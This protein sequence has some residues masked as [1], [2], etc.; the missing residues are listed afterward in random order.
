MRRKRLFTSKLWLPA[1]ASLLL[2]TGRGALAQMTTAAIHG[3]VTDPSGAVVP[4]AKVIALNTA[5]GISTSTTS[6]KSG[7]YIFT[8]LQ[9]GDYAI[10]VDAFGF[11]NFSATSV[12][13][14]ANANREVN[15]VLKIGGGAQTVQ[16]TATA[17]QVETSNTQLE[18]VATSDELESLPLEGRDPAGLAKLEPGIMESSDR[19]GSF[20]SNGNQTAQNSYMIDGAD[21]NDGPLQNE[22]IQVNPDALSGE[23]IVTSTMNPEFARNSGQVVNEVIKSGTN[24]IHG[25]GFEFYRD[26]FLNNGN[27]FATTRPVFHQNLYGGTV[28]GPMI[29]NKLFAFLAYQGYR[30]RTATTTLQ[31]T[32]SGTKSTTSP[33]GQFAGAFSSDT[34]WGM[35]FVAD[36]ATFSNASTN[37][38]NNLPYCANIP[39]GTYS[40]SLSC[41]PTPFSVNGMPAGTPWIEAFNNGGAGSATINIAPSAWN[42]IATSLIQNY[43]PAANY[44]VSAPTEYNFNALNTGAE[45]QGIVRLDYTLSSRDS[46]W[47]SSVFQ[48]SP[49]FNTLPFGGS[50]F[51]GS[52]QV[53]AEHF[54]IFSGDWTHTFSSNKLNDLHGGYYRFNFAAVIPAQPVQP[55]TA[56]FDITPQLAA[57]A[58]I[59]YIGV[60]GLFNL[61]FS[62]EGP[63]PRLDTNLTYLDSFTWVRGN[64][65][66]KFGASFEQF[67]VH[68]PFGYYNNG[69]YSFDGGVAGGG[70]YSSGD[71][72]IDFV[73]GIPDTYSQTNDGFIDAVANETYFYVQ[74]NWRATPD[75]TLNFGSGWD[76]EQP[77]QNR[78]YNGL[79]IIC[80]ANNSTTSK[81][82]PGG[83]PGLTYS[84]DPGC[85]AAGSPTTKYNHF[86]PRVGFAW[87]PSS[88]P[89]A[90]NGHPGEHDFSIRAG[91]GIYFNRDQ[92]E[93]SLQNLGDPP[94]LYESHGASDFGGSPGFANPYA[95]VAGNGSEPNPY[96]YTPPSA[97]GAVNWGVY[98]Q[99]DV[100]AFAPT[101]SVPYAYNFNL[102]IQRSLPGAMLLQV[103][104]V[105]SMGHHTTTWFEGDNITQSGHDACLANP[106]CNPA[107]IHLFFPQYTAQPAIVPGTGNG[108]IS[109]L[110]NG[111]PWYLS[112][113]N[114]NTEG[115][116]NYNAFQMSLIKSPT[117]GLQFTLGYTYSHA[118]DDSSGY[119]SG[120]GGDGG[121][122]NG[123]R[124][125]NYV[126]GF[127]YLNYGDSDY[128]ARQRLVASYVY[129]IPATGF[130]RSNAILREGLSGWGIGGLTAVQDGFPISVTMGAQRSYWCDGYSYFGCPDVPE[131]SSF[132]IKRFNPR[133]SANN[134]YFDT[135]PFSPEPLGTFGNTRRNFF[136][137]PG[138]NYTNLEIS[139]NFPFSAEGSRYLQMR[140]EAF[141]AFNH[142]NFAP[143]GGSYA[144]SAAYGQVFGAVNSVIV[145]QDPNADPQPGRAVQL[146][147]K[148]YF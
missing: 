79:G 72:L 107:S 8:Q 103:G 143:P 9:V 44:P 48:S 145:S 6:D 20:S 117:H 136:H 62:F 42:S 119:E 137:G 80:W 120:T 2:F 55:S 82:Y 43:V 11:Q 17:V 45:D 32:L 132:S 29:K 104:Y 98:S 90:L 112:V 67:R 18:Q 19:F 118:L 31:P 87:S 100:N 66:L 47:G 74:D 61:G 33:P 15:A 4:G 147:G 128:D 36:N 50:S 93:Q 71:P 92:E 113:A 3:T 140:L 123:G 126:P 52:P 38:A 75:L 88:G 49:S 138:F 1:I 34:N 101:Y 91:F 95:D 114:Q 23:T 37:P 105:G 7:Y 58:G 53:G 76:A 110:P 127:Q 40:D 111:V 129:T 70:D 131:T 144:N 54:K 14:N 16:V 21:I 115:S 30:N 99:L 26:T 64:H 65:T 139:K 81:I 77:N 109:G 57:G 86:A 22:G 148:V 94:A 133:S 85:N 73:L 106:S 146:V 41:N 130:L 124:V 63:Q 142:A 59:P 27:Y 60:G 39:N 89:S 135:T 121:Y 5:T 84:G 96:P 13:L 10:T 141:N 108:A 68:N 12:V 28:G 97:G 125:Y 134:Q 35:G 116:S 56:G 83:P 46:I 69:S 24:K 51:P 78:Q 25:S 122:G 102:N